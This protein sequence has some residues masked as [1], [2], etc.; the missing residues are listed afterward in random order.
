ML[1]CSSDVRTVQV[2]SFLFLILLMLEFVAFFI[3]RGDHTG[4]HSVPIF[5]DTYPQ[6]VSVFIFSWA[7]VIFVPSW[8]NEKAVETSVNKV[9]WSS[10]IASWVGYVAIGVLCASVFGHSD[11]GLDN[12]LV[13]LSKSNMPTLTRVTAYLF[14]LGVIAP[15]I[16]VCSVTTR[17]NLFVGGVVGKKQS[18]FWACVA[19]WLVG[20]IFCQGELFA[21]L[22][23]WTSLVFNGLVNFLVP[24][25]MYLTSLKFVHTGGAPDTPVEE[26]QVETEEM[27]GCE[28]DS[29]DTM[30]DGSRTPVVRANSHSSLQI[31]DAPLGPAAV[32]KSSLHSPLLLA[33][34]APESPT[35]THAPT[36]HVRVLMAD[37]MSETH[38]HAP[39]RN[40][41]MRCWS[42]GHNDDYSH[43]PV[44]PFPRFMR[45]YAYQIVLVLVIVTEGIIL[46]QTIGDIV[47][48]AQG[49]DALG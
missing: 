8:L 13:S 35:K 29:L 12:M 27:V 47:F 15:G 21:N 2:G 1:L 19:P 9:I 45:P 23:N 36:T 6:L 38:A 37:S 40:W 20:W 33:I 31:N 17:Y 3:W 44:Y 43:G 34:T 39:R 18:Y 14:S 11:I 7:Y 41:F 26:E 24:F 46:A 32:V 30:N 48:A 28:E 4:F 10:G 16:P 25:L 42:P 49:G 5:G 22:L